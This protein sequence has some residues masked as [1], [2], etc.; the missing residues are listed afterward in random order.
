MDLYSAYRPKTKPLPGWV[1]NLGAVV[2]CVVGTAVL[3]VWYYLPKGNR[4]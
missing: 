1:M 2:V 4:K 3:V